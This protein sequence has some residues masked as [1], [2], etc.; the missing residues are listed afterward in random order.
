[1]RFTSLSSSLS[2]FT[3]WFVLQAAAAPAAG[4]QVL[5]PQDFKQTIAD[6]VWCVFCIEPLILFFNKES[7]F[8]EHFSPYCRHCRN[9]EPTWNRVVDNFEKEKPDLGIHLAQVNCALNG[10]E[11]ALQIFR[12]TNRPSQSWKTCAPR[13]VLQDTLK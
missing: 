3:T 5:T 9:F 11:R 8:I 6:G 10:G 2:L 13:T 4:S 7:R 12:A 1:M